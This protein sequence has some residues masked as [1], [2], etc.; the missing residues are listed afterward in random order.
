MIH[1]WSGCGVRRQWAK[2]TVLA[3]RGLRRVPFHGHESRVVQLKFQ[4]IDCFLNKIAV[5][6][7]DVL[8]LF[9]RD[10]HV[11][12]AAC[13]VAETGGLEPGL[14]RLAIHLFFEGRQNLYPG[15]NRRCWRSCE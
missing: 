5:L 7:A 3:H 14:E 6:V 2:T 4:E 8:K 10:T 9:R 1:R 12:S 11:E 13:N 15:V